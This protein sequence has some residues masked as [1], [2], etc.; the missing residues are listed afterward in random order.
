MLRHCRQRNRQS[1]LACTK[2]KRR[3]VDWAA[4]Y[5]WLRI[6]NFAQLG[7]SA[8]PL[9]ATHVNTTSATMA[10]SFQLQPCLLMGWLLV[11]IGQPPRCEY[12]RKAFTTSP[13]H[14]PT[15][16]AARD[17]PPFASPRDIIHIQELPVPHVESAIADHRES[18]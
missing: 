17:Q 2:K 8:T 12:T 18:I 11:A 14:S 13:A 15:V 9:T 5:I 4:L 10:A 3:P 7:M 6:D 16:S 1:Y